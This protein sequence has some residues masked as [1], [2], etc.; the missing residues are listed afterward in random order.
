MSS[1]RC[2]FIFIRSYYHKEINPKDLVKEYLK[3]VYNK[4]LR[5]RNLKQNDIKLTLV[6][7]DEWVE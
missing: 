4:K 6:E 2:N 3:D 7:S 1:Y 5:E